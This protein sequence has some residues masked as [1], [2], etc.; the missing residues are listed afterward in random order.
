MR[1]RDFIRLGTGLAAAYAARPT[2]ALA[3][4]YPARPIKLVVPYPPGGVV[5]VVARHWAEKAGAIV[6]GSFVVENQAGGGGTLGAGS[7]KRANADGHT[8]LFGE[9]SCLIIA[10]YLMAA[11]PYDPQKDFAAVS[12]VATSSTSII[13]HPSVPAKTLAEFITYAKENQDKMS[14]GSAG[15]GTVTHLAGELFKQLIGTPKITHVP[16]RGA[17]P[18]LVDAVSG[19]VP[20]VTPNITGQ[21]LQMHK[22]GKLRILAVCAP[23]RLRAAPDIP[24]ASETVPGM[25]LQLTSG[26]LAP[27]GTADDIVAKLSAATAKI[28]ADPDF[29][30]ILATSGLEGRADSTAQTAKAFW[31]SERARLTPIMTAAGL[32]P[33]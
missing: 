15:A 18:A 2:D 10:P 7:V 5:D 23:E 29:Q 3:Q 22:E 14:Y 28:V 9:T 13:V 12:L 19:Q 26:V 6:G 17:G 8:L 4:S 20:M 1:R 32:T 16:Y 21:I 11:P 31:Q 33:S 27:A 30:R 24:T 25:V